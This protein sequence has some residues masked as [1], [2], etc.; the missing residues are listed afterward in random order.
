MGQKLQTGAIAAALLWRAASCRKSSSYLLVWRS[1]PLDPAEERG[2]LVR[3]H[4]TDTVATS[5]N[6]RHTSSVPC[7]KFLLLRIPQATGQLAQL[8][9]K[10]KKSGK[11]VVMFSSSVHG[12]TYVRL[13]TA[14]YIFIMQRKKK[15][16]DVFSMATC[17]VLQYFYHV[18][19]DISGNHKTT[20][21]FKQ[22]SFKKRA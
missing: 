21:L 11:V 19:S 20:H 12:T 5:T 3:G 4:E 6:Y 15:H 2:Q 8:C 18:P 1:V 13:F 16:Y 17:N 10:K 14:E 7:L 9:K 22:A